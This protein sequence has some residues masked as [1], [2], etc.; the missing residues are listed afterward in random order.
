MEELG[1]LFSH[2]YRD[3]F[4]A[5]EILVIAII[6]LVL[7]AISGIFFQLYPKT[8]HRVRASKKGA[9]PIRIDHL[10]LKVDYYIGNNQHKEGYLR[11]LSLDAAS[12][13][14]YDVDHQKNSAISLDLGT[15]FD[16]HGGKSKLIRA[17]VAK[18]R[19]LGGFPE[20]WL[21]EVKFLGD[22]EGEQASLNSILMDATSHKSAAAKG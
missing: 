12:L 8:D 4:L 7:L 5:N 2:N 1:F 21:V 6:I 17:R 20:S 19:S 10:F 15:A 18:H 13:L 14:T 16:Q 3:Y 9:F 22:D 11:S